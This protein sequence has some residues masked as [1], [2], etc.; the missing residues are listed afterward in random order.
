MTYYFAKQLDGNFAAVVGAVRA[1]LAD[2]G[3][4]I[5]SEIDVAATM[6]AKLNVEFRPYLILGA[7]NPPLAHK[8]LLADDKIGLMLPCNVVV[9]QLDTGQIEVAAIDPQ[10]SIGAADDPVLLGIAR[11]VGARLERMIDELKTPLDVVE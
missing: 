10:A 6:K 9:Q 5:I 3:F 7:C 4:G 2:E 1:A 8:A 11:Q